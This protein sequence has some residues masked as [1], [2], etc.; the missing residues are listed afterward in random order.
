MFLPVPRL[1]LVAGHIQ[2]PMQPVLNPP[3]TPHD[4]VAPLRC[5]V[6]RQAHQGNRVLAEQD[7]AEV[8]VLPAC[9]Q[10]FALDAHFQDGLPFQQVVGYLPQ[11][12]QF[13]GLWPLRIRLWSLRKVTSRLQCSKFSMLQCARAARNICSAEPARLL[14]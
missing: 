6:V 14:M 11:R 4:A 3:M 12:R 2:Y 1:V 9:L 7:F 13:R 8:I 5:Q 10:A